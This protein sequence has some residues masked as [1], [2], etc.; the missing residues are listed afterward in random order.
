MLARNVICGAVFAGALLASI[1]SGYALPIAMDAPTPEARP[2][3]ILAQYDTGR[4]MRHDRRMDHMRM[5]RLRH[6]MRRERRRLRHEMKRM[7][8]ERRYSEC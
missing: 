5:H 4:M 3:I 2:A 6:E 1:G 7:R 8:H